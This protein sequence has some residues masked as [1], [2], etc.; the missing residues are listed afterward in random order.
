MNNACYCLILIA[1]FPSVCFQSLR[2]NTQNRI[3]VQFIEIRAFPHESKC[4]FWLQAVNAFPV[5]LIFRRKDQNHPFV[6]LRSCTLYH[7]IGIILLPHLRIPHVTGQIPR[8]IRIRHQKLL[9]LKGLSIPADCQ[10][11]VGFPAIVNIII[12]AL[13]LHISCVIHIHH[14][15]FHKCWARIGT[16]TVIRLIRLKRGSLIFP[17]NQILAGA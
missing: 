7:V 16:V 4:F 3:S 5:F 6:F 10:H 15:V 13:K 9:G 2:R 11:C 12:S 8:I 1:V 17:M 14:T